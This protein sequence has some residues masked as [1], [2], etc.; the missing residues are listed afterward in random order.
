MFPFCSGLR[1]P[2][3][4]CK[5][6]RVSCLFLR[7]SWVWSRLHSKVYGYPSARGESRS[8]R[9]KSQSTRHKSRSARHKFR[10]ARRN[11]GR[12]GAHPGR[13][14]ANLGRQG[15]NKLICALSAGICAVPTKIRDSGPADVSNPGR[16]GANLGRQAAL[17]RRIL[18]RANRKPDALNGSGLSA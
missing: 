16:Q 15:A 4:P 6:T 13:Q 9:R 18:G 14:G 17:G 12:Q 2:Y 7:Y 5:P 1:V 10:S 11:P 8:A 3:K